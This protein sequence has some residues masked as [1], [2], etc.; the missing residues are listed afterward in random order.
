MTSSLSADP[1]ATGVA[2]DIKGMAL[3]VGASA[4]NSKP[5]S[6]PSW[7]RDVAI[8]LAVAAP[9]FAA[10]SFPAMAAPSTLVL[11]AVA[12]SLCAVGFVRPRLAFVAVL[13][14]IGARSSGELSGLRPVSTQPIDQISVVLVDDPR[15]AAFGWTS[16]VR[17]GDSN[18]QLSVPPGTPSYTAGDRLVVS[19]TQR[20]GF[21]QSPWQISRRLVGAISASEVHSVAVADGPIGAANLVRETIRS[22]AG[23]LSPS[24][25]VLFTGLVFGDDRGQDVVVADNFRASGLGHLL[26]VSGQNVVFVLLLAAPVLSR[27]RSVPARI[28]LTLTVL[29]SFGFL[30]RFEASVTRALVMAGLA[31]L[32]HA[33]GRP[34]QAAAVLPPAVAGLLLFDPLL[35][36]SLAFQLSVAATLGLIVLSPRVVDLLPGPLPLRLAVGATLSAQL[37]V[38]PLLFSSFGRVSVVAVP[39]NLLA[40]PAAA[41]A[42]MWGLVAGPIAG[43]SPNWLAA[44][45]HW[46]TH[47][48][49]WWIDSVAAAFARLDVGRVTPWHLVAIVVG[50]GAFRGGRFPRP[51]AVAL[52]LVAIVPT[53]VAPAPLPP[54]QHRLVDGVTVARSADGHD[55]VIVSSSARPGD[56]IESLREARLGRIDL[57]IAESG[58]RK[59]G[60]LIALVSR[61]FDVIDIWAPDGHQVPGARVVDP[62][63]GS[64]GTLVL[65]QR[66]DGTIEIVT[67]G[68]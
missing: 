64:V 29:A 1:P 3:D 49:L 27:V 24:R 45:V 39:A 23:S 55:V 7:R 46:P 33:I 47:L 19:G 26:A 37:F 54:G 4:R 6:A 28:A 59:S 67:T 68:A 2:A 10:R 18:V 66:N 22:G 14:V 21:P 38:A 41:G 8:V 32:A 48:L 51:F 17:F 12:V 56:L 20:G 34:A 63:T 15:P 58:S 25:R 44:V 5:V 16:M 60:R 43:V 65:T 30:T 57:L 9:L 50:A 61:R 31:V 13:L 53:F 36:W 42:M 11:M 40:A 62:I 35:A 52:L